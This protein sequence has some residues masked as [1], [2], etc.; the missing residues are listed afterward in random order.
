MRIVRL[1][2]QDLVKNGQLLWHF[3]LLLFLSAESKASGK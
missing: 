2:G 3:L 1:E